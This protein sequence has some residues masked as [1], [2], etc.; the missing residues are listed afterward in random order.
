[1]APKQVSTPK[2]VVAA[3]DVHALGPT[4]RKANRDDERVLTERRRSLDG[5]FDG[6]PVPG[7]TVGD[8]DLA[9]FRSTYLPSVVAPEV[10]EENG[11]PESQQ[12]NS[13]RM[14]DGTLTPTVLGLLVLGFDPSAFVPG[15]YLQFV[16]YDDTDVDAAIIDEQELRH[17]VVDLAERLEV[18]LTGHLHTRVVEETGF[19]ERRQPDYPLA[20]LRE[21]CM[22]AV[23][24]RNYETS[25]APIRILWFSGRPC[26][27]IVPSR[28]ITDGWSVYPRSSPRRCSLIPQLQRAGLMRSR[29]CVITRVS[30]RSHTTRESRCSICGQPMA[31]LAAH[32]PMYINAAPNFS[33][34]LR[35]SSIGS[36][37]CELPSIAV[38]FRDGA[39]VRPGRG[40]YFLS[41]K[42]R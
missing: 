13:L 5:P 19:R 39:A 6:R 34:S 9:L 31:L 11:R 36:T 28:P 29:P 15:A 1:M 38:E 37:K 10:I 16:R 8:V 35:A 21:V 18:L 27:S 24:H 20:A 7:S 41:G 25:N 26:D 3:M 32:K 12:L 40:N 22:N 33:S 14:T 4:T 42:G 23:M 17:N 30:C 2:N